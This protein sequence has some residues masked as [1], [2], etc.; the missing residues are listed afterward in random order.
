[1]ARP[2]FRGVSERRGSTTNYFLFDLLGSVRATSDASGAANELGLT[3]AF[4]NSVTTSGFGGATT[5]RPFGFVGGAQYQTD[6]ESGLQL[7]SPTFFIFP[8]KNG[9]A[10]A[11]TFFGKAQTVVLLLPNTRLFSPSTDRRQEIIKEEIGKRLEVKNAE[12]PLRISSRQ[13]G[14]VQEHQRDSDQFSVQGGLTLME[15]DGLGNVTRI[16]EVWRVI[17]SSGIVLKRGG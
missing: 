8:L 9:C 15:L 7:L 13:L 14:S 4:G 16:T 12:Q 2:T 10:F 1:M 6:A 17:P 5:T 11:D 3:D